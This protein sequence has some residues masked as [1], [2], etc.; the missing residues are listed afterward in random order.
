[1]LVGVEVLPIIV[2]EL[3]VQGVQVDQVAVVLLVYGIKMLK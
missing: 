2:V 3:L 1:M